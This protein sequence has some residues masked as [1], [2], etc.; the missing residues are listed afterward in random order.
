MVKV[1]LIVEGDDGRDDEEDKEK[2]VC[3]D[4]SKPALFLGQLSGLE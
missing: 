3:A 4:N 2:G 1:M